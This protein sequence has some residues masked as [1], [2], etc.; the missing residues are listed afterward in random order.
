MDQ[1]TPAFTPILLGS[2]FNA[3]GMARTLYEI[4]GKP[5]KTFAEVNLAP[6]RYSKIVDMEF[7]DGF[8]EDPVWFETMLKLKERYKDAEGP[9]ILIACGGDGYAELISRHKAELEDVFVCP[10]ID[11]DLI[12]KLN[13]KVSFYEMC[14]KFDMPYPG[15]RVI[16]KEMYDNHE[17]ID[18]PFEYP[19]ALKAA[20]SVEWLDVH[21]EG[22]KKAFTIQNEAELKDIIANLTTMVTSLK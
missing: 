9:V 2:D 10:Y 3:Y 6:T 11:Y 15:T 21:F 13:D 17:E 22:R 7:I 16:T 1:T 19:V 14:E 8:A 4:Y 18:Q 5:V 20:N 12:K